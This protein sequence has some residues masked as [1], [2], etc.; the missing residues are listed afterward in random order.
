MPTIQPSPTGAAVAVAMRSVTDALAL[1]E[2]ARGVLTALVSE[3]LEARG[4]QI[5][6][7]TIAELRTLAT[8]ASRRW[9]AAQQAGR[10]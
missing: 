8:E 9:D 4:R 7:L 3:F 2:G 10:S 5:D 6:S 1:P